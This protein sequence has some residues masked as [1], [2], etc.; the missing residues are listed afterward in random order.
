[1]EGGRKKRRS[2]EGEERVKERASSDPE[3][4]GWFGMVLRMNGQTGQVRSGQVR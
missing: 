2:R 3:V 4:I 1:M